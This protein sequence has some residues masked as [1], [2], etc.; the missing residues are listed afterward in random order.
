MNNLIGR[1]ARKVEGNLKPNVQIDKSLQQLTL[2][3]QKDD[4]IVEEQ[5][6]LSDKERLKKITKLRNSKG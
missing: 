2:N 4:Q 5:V 3:P 1:D 6:V